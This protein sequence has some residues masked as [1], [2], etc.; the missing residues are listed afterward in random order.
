VKSP[1]RRR[2]DEGGTTSVGGGAV[3]A[4]DVRAD[5]TTRQDVEGLYPICKPPG[6]T[7]H[8]VV[9]AVRRLTGE[10]HSGHTGTL[11][12]PAAG[13]L[14]VLVGQGP[15]RLAEYLLDLEKTYL[16][17]FRFGA[18]TDTQDYTG[19]VTWV[20]SR[21][22]VLRLSRGDI[23]DVLPRFRG[24]CEQ[25]PPMISAVRVGGQRLYSLAREGR[26]VEREARRVI[27]Y[28]LEILDFD[29]RPRRP[30]ARLRVVC[31][32]GT[33]IRTLA[34]DVGRA[35]GVGAHLGF[36]VRE[37]IGPFGLTATATLEELAA[38]SAGNALST[39][40][41]PAAVA[42]GHLTAI[43]LR[44]HECDRLRRGETLSYAEA[45]LEQPLD[46]ALS[47]QRAPGAVVRVL[48]EDGD[49]VAIATLSGGR[50]RP[51]KV[52]RPWMGGNLR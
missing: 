45:G 38:A 43:P 42:V 50:V 13:V 21:E 2:P 17:E 40:R 7:S 41:V 49:L 34:D 33:Y 5:G 47:G 19:R 20:S 16:A 23:E 1:E 37:S 51:R 25:V 4:L 11:D 18:T 3:A 31:S 26:A 28:G 14:L 10:R 9:A 15:V 8:D 39:V 12:P 44:A 35:L 36:L 48:T 22:E 30:T 24:P 46:G 52:L 6:M 29:S 32:R 27:I